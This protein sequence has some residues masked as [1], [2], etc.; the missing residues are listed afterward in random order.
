M[1]ESTEGDEEYLLGLELKSML[2][3]D[4]DLE[5]AIYQEEENLGEL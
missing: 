2:I 4:D 1:L 3:S 5:A